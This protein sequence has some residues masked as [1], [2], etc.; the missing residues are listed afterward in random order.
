M[1]SDNTVRV[2]IVED[3]ATDAEILRRSLN[4]LEVSPLEVSFARTGDEAKSLLGRVSFDLLLLDLH[5]PDV[6][7]FELVHEAKKAQA[8]LKVVVCTSLNSN[9]AALEAGRIGAD[10][11]I[12]KD[13]LLGSSLGRTVRRLLRARLQEIHKGA[14]KPKLI[15]EP[16]DVID[17]WLAWRF[18]ADKVPPLPPPPEILRECRTRYAALLRVSEMKGERELRLAMREFEEFAHERRVPA[19]TLIQLHR[20]HVAE[21][22]PAEKMAGRQRFVLFEVL[23][24]LLER[25]RS[26]ETAEKAE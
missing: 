6:V 13:D 14:K 1:P 15:E 19:E 4:R 5:L 23:A 20:Q 24:A 18:P 16:S 21:S 26:G 22:S 9:D 7:G 3:E 8:Q 11:Y 12:V 17:T 10:D 2:L 25:Y